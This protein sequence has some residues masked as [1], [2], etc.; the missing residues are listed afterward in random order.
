MQKHAPKWQATEDGSNLPFSK[1]PEDKNGFDGIALEPQRLRSFIISYNGAE[2]N[3]VDT[4][5]K[6]NLI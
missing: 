3:K 1:A 5:I 4:Q 2:K 6:T